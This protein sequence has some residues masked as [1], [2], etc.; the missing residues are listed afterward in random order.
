M[1]VG[2]TLFR[3]DG[4]AYCSP[5]FSR[6]GL[7]ATFTIEVMNF[8]MAASQT[9]DPVIEHRNSEDTS[10]TTAASFN[11]ITG[12]GVNSK[13]ATGLKEIVR[14]KIGFSG[15]DSTDAAHFLIQAPS[16]RPYA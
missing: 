5:E 13:D 6:G 16:W 15:T 3:L 7:A 12:V 8:D 4:N 10:W 1:I 9:L 14:I 11:P 2:T